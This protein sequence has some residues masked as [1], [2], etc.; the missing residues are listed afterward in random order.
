MSERSNMS[1]RSKTQNSPWRAKTENLATA[2]AAGI[3][4]GVSR[5]T[6]GRFKPSPDTL[7]IVGAVAVAA[8]ANR[9]EDLNDT[10]KVEESVTERSLIGITFAVATIF[11]GVDGALDRYLNKITKGRKSSWYGELADVIADRFQE[12]IM[13][14]SRALSARKRGDRVGE[15][16]AWATTATNTLPSIVRAASEGFR[17]RAVAENGKNPA[18]ALGTRP[19]RAVLGGIA[20]FCPEGWGIKFQNILD[21]AATSANMLAVSSRVKDMIHSEPSDLSSE[22]RLKSR[23]RFLALAAFEGLLL[24]DIYKT[25]KNGR[26]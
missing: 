25:I 26:H 24:Y 22:K 3:Y 20:T 15:V 4:H 5:L 1:E 19:G 8:L 21:G 17:D 23:Q 2:C 11:D 7:T 13:G 10:A 18:E 12:Y 16:L 6:K 9:A 14:K